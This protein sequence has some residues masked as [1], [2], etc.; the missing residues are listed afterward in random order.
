MNISMNVSLKEQGVL[1]VTSTYFPSEAQMHIMRI[2][3]NTDVL[4]LS[5]LTWWFYTVAICIIIH[6]YKMYNAL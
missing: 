2:V 1:E 3:W 5:D 4:I 6:I